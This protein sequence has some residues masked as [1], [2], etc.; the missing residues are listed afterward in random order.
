MRDTLDTENVEAASILSPQSSALSP[1]S[2]VI[3]PQHSPVARTRVVR[4]ID[5]LNIGGPAKHVVWLTCG[6]ES[7]QFESTLIT[8]TIPPGEGDMSYFAADNGVEPIVVKQMSRE[9]GFRDLLVIAKLTCLFFQ[10]RPDV[11]HT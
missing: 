5:R 1:Q 8:G 9:L 3:T 11:V 7:D 4:I 2:S 6:L 10:I